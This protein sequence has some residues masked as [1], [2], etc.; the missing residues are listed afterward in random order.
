MAFKHQGLPSESI[1]PDSEPGLYQIRAFGLN[2]LSNS[3]NF[4]VT[5][6]PWVVVSGNESEVNPAVIAP[7]T[8]WQDECPDRGR[9]YYRLKFEQDQ[10]LQLQS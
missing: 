5:S 8:I 9:N 1:P 4:M 6:E 7:G 10:K 3:R 2:G